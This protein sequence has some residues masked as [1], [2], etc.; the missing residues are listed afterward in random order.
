MFGKKRRNDLKDI[1]EKKGYVL[2]KMD[3]VPTES[4]DFERAVKNYKVLIETENTIR[5]G[6]SVRRSERIGTVVKVG[7]FI[8][9]SVSAIGVPI[10]LAHLAYRNDQQM[11]LKN[12]TI[13]NL[14]G[15]K[16]DK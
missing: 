14:I 2:D 7:T 9:S 6:R 12:G 4:D 11:N 13:W 3:N 1:D 15:K 5:D 10:Y 8:V 16:F